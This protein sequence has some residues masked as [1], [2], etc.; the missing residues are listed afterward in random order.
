MT[1]DYIIY[2]LNTYKFSEPLE[3]E[4]SYDKEDNLHVYRNNKLNLVGCGATKELA[5]SD[6]EMCFDEM[7]REWL[8][9]ADDECS[10]RL[11]EIKQYLKKLVI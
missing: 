2:E 11:N 10:D 4:Y 8:S 9:W 7:Y 6:F 1:L 3:L 5:L